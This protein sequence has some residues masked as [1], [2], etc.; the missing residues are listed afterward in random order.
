MGIKAMEM[1]FKSVKSLQ[2]AKAHESS[3][4]RKINLIYSFS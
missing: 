1:F 3:K 4:P 2:A